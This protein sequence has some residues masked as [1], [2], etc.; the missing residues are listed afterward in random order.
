MRIN[1]WLIVSIGFALIVLA[2]GCKKMDDHYRQFIE[3]G[4][5][6]Y[7][8]K[9]DSI[10][11]RGGDGRIEISWLLLSDPKV[12]SYKL[13]WDNRT[14]SLT[15]EIHKTSEIDTVRV[16]LNNMAEGIHYFEIYMYDKDGNSSV[17]AEAT[18]SVYGPLYEESLLTRTFLSMRK[19]G[20]D[21]EVNWTP[22]G[23]DLD[24]VEIRYLNNK[25]DSIHRLI[26]AAI[27]LDTIRNV[28]LH[29][30]YEYR[31][32]F[33]PDST[34]LDTFYTPYTFIDYEEYAKN[35][36]LNM[37]LNTTVQ[38]GDQ[39]NQLSILVST[40]FDGVYE[41]NDIKNAT[42]TDITSNFSLATSTTKEPWGPQDLVSLF[43]EGKPLYI[44]FRYITLPQG[45]NGLQR[46]WKVSNF[47]LANKEGAVIST[48]DAAEFTLIH[49]GPFE[50]G[51]SSISTS[52][53]TLRG[54]K[55]DTESKTE[56]WAI[57]KAINF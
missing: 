24:H 6:I 7:I 28:S 8:A 45:D 14:D 39:E 33:L 13:Y 23:S 22:A 26:P 41:M 2:L 40:D 11:V 54:N 55:D 21:I 44:A 16:M 12:R 34:A 17:Q 5:T 32:A 15:G 53:I 29:N 27:E 35:K 10:K 20:S 37:S 57:S 52:T 25:G 43:A 47:E 56:D 1:I 3:D 31:S 30:E 48:L 4:E 9:A 42:W 36:G 46:T 49:D 18:G 51:R 50:S 19:I 38:Y